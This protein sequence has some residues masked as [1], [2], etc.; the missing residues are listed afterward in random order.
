MVLTRADDF[1]IH[2]TS[3]P[4]AYAGTDRNFYDRYFFNGYSMQA[5]DKAFFAAAFGVLSA[6]EHRR[7]RLRGGAERR[8]DGPARLPLAEDGAAGSAGRAGEDRGGRAPE[9]P[10]PPGRRA[11][12]GHQGRHHLHRPR[13][14]HRG[15]ALRPPQRPAHLHG[16]HPPDP[17]RP[18]GRAGSRSTAYARASTAS[19]APATAPGA[20]APSARG[21]A[22]TSPRPWRRSSSG[23]GRPPISRTAA[24]SSTPTTTRP[25]RPGTGARCGSR[26]TAPRAI[27]TARWCRSTGRAA[28]ATLGR[29]L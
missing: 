10:A 5:G 18:L 22:R 24:F 3:E 29:P 27:S 23:C 14:T 26:T 6:P 17:E 8:R 11:R 13:R 16:L 2:Q 20:C 4:I 25:E 21:T 12:A 1:P 7:R 9:G 15:A 19:W 28:R